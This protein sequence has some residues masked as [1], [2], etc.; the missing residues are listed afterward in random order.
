M[1]NRVSKPF[2]I[3]D[4]TN[5][6]SIGATW[7]KPTVGE[8]KIVFLG[9]PTLEEAKNF[10]GE[11]YDQLVCDISI[12]GMEY[13]QPTQLKWSFAM[14]TGLKSLCG[15]LC[16]YFEKVNNSKFTGSPIT[17]L[18]NKG[19]DN[20]NTYTVREALKYVGEKLQELK[21][22]SAIP[23]NTTQLVQTNSGSEGRQ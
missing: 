3:S 5:N 19:T 7:F 16:L 2:N 6:I 10:A 22:Q 21:Q 11:T 14:C 9:E 17:L 20:K 4:V 23:P 12:Q 8:Y 13:R 1:E 18:V 15:Q